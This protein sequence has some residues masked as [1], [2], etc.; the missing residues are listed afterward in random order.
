MADLVRHDVYGLEVSAL[1]DCAGGGGG[2][3]PGHRGQ[4]HH[5]AG[6]LHVAVQH[7]DI[8]TRQD[9]R[10][11]PV[12]RIAISCNILRCLPLKILSELRITFLISLP[13]AGWHTLENISSNLRCRNL[14]KLSI[15]ILNRSG[16]RRKHFL[17]TLLIKRSNKYSS[18]LAFTNE[19]FAE[20]QCQCVQIAASVCS[21]KLLTM[22]QPWTWWKKDS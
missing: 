2:A 22:P 3:H 19:E 1:V 8:E 12:K 16:S 13:H 9:D 7:V 11:I 4:A 6:H 10:M 21:K 17:W 15:Y 20:K 5:L 18:V 14:I